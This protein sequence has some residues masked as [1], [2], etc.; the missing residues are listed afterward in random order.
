MNMRSEVTAIRPAADECSSRL[1]DPERVALVVAALPEA[2]FIDEI[3]EGFAVLAD[4]NR[5]RLLVSLLEGG[6]LCVHD[7]A[8]ATAMGESAVSHALRILRARRIVKVRRS[9]RL[10]FY[11]LRDSHVRTLL[12]V[13][14][15]HER[16]GDD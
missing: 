12:H 1:V 10:A 14:L 2:E 15:E 9:G 16:H 7:L 6:E 8:A 4:A 5:L 3:A 11:S 13:A